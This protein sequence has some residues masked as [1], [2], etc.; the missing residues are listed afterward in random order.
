MYK[1]NEGGQFQGKLTVTVMWIP[2]KF[3]R[4]I[5]QEGYITKEASIVNGVKAVLNGVGKTGQMHAEK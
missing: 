2:T 4:N 5:E 1:T 3:K